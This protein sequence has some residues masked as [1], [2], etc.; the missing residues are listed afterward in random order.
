MPTFLDQTYAAMSEAPD[1]EA[2]NLQ[3]Y[4][5]LSDA[6]LFLMLEEEASDDSAKPLVFE[7]A[8]G[9]FA[10][11]FDREDRLAE[12]VD[13]P[14]PFVALS[15]RRIAKLLA[16]EGIG[17]GLNL[18]VAPS[19]MLLPPAAIDWLHEVLGTNSIVTEATPERLHAPKGLPETL[20]S[21]LDTKIANMSGVAS[22]AYL[23]GVT[24]LG[25]LNGHMLAFVDTP[26]A[27]RD[28]MAEAISEALVF[29]GV[30]AGQLDVTFLDQDNPLLSEFAK[31]GLTFEIPELIL[32]TALK[33]L[34]PGMDP[35]KPPKL[36]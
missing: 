25:G 8:D 32:P 9:P 3:F 28:G 20:V 14:T 17:L 36:R 22:A 19:S 23:V 2:A 7:T 21:A 18:G 27:A 11:V 31:V 1:D 5:R 16:G 15:G 30:E 34:A 13:T 12:F 35:D 10:L 24:Y 33:P 26:T 6:E 29:S 4:E